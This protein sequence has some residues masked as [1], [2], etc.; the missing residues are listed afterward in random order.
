MSPNAHRKS[1]FTLVELIIV[2]GI[3]GLL[4]SVMLPALKPVVNKSRLVR[5]TA[6][7]R[8]I[9]YSVQLYHDDFNSYPADADRSVP[10]GLES[11][12]QGGEWPSAVLPGSLFDW[13]NWDEPDNPGTKI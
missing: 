4:A 8:S 6:D 13:D 3:I 12:L 11:Y 2:I 5:A 1:G 9:Y 10:P 7:L